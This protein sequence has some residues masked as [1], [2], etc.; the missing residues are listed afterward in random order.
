MVREP[1]SLILLKCK[2]R[3]WLAQKDTYHTARSET[4]AQEFWQGICA[5]SREGLHLEDCEVNLVTSPAKH[6]SAWTVGVPSHFGFQ[7]WLSPC[8][9]FQKCEYECTAS[10]LPKD[11]CLQIELL[12]M[13]VSWFIVRKILRWFCT[14]SKWS[15][16]AW[17]AKFHL[18]ERVAW[19]FT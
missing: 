8:L 16:A 3:R 17:N 4:K 11:N 7:S 10:S 18:Q 14:W 15:M 6:G 2:E 12:L 13:K 19:C 5:Y 9:R 1:K